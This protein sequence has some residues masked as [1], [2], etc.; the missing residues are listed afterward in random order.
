MPPKKSAKKAPSRP[1]NTDKI[2]ESPIGAEDSP[3]GGRT[4]MA[5]V[6]KLPE[7]SSAGRPNDKYLKLCEAVIGE[8]GAG[9]PVK[10]IEFS[11]PTSAIRAVNEIQSGKRPVPGGPGQWELRAVVEK[12]EGQEEKGSVLYVEWLGE[13][14]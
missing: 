7:P 12:V 11:H 5:R 14:E 8:F 1:R 10:L 9:E 3:D 13:A 2:P 4:V 6:D